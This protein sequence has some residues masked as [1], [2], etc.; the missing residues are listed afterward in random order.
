MLIH[1]TDRTQNTQFHD[2]YLAGIDLDLSQCLIVFSF[3]DISLVNNVLKDR[4]QVIQCGGYSEAE[5]KIILKDYVWP[6][7]LNQLKFS[8]LDIDLTEQSMKFL[9][10]EYSSSEQGVRSLIRIA[11]TIVT[12]L[13]MIRIA[14]EDV[15]S[16]YK[17]YIKLEFPLKLSEQIIRKLLC[18]HEKV[19]EHNLSMYI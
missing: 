15:M 11:E 19:Q 16:E 3:N 4:M 18:D 8:V 13:N 17:F 12:R 14:D 6:K 1:L 5:K 2:R 7:L 9:I 10:S